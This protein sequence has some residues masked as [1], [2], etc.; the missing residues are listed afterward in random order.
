MAYVQKNN[1][2]NVTPCGRR[3]TFMHDNAPMTITSPNTYMEV[4]SPL[5]KRKKRKKSN[6]PRRT[7]KGKNRNF[8]T[9]KEGAGMTAKGVR[10]YRKKNPGS[11][12]KTAV[13]EKNP[14]KARAARRRSFCARS[15]NWKGERGRAARRRWRC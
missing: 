12:L 4:E 1:P 13:T 2:F 11:K 6:E 14:S 15:K 10:E 5:E 3:R 7:T 9:V 8:R